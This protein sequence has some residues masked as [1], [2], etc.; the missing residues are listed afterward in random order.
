MPHDLHPGQ[1][2][3]GDLALYAG[4]PYAVSAVAVLRTV[5]GELTS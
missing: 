5:D 2:T 1:R 3:L 4:W